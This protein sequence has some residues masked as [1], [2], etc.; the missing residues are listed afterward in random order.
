MTGHK[1]TVSDPSKSSQNLRRLFQP[2]TQ[3]EDINLKLVYMGV[4][5]DN[6]GGKQGNKFC[7]TSKLG[8]LLKLFP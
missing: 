1:F 4:I 6:L 5:K 2:T 8:Y 3:Q 7:K